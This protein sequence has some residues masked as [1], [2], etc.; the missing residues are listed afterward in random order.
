MKGRQPLWP[1]AIMRNYIRP[2]ALRAEIAKAITWHVFRHSPL[3]SRRTMFVSHYM[4]LVGATQVASGGLPL[5]GRYVPLAIALSGPAIVN[6][7][8]YH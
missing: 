5:S 4:W 7:I 8:V 1:E 2:A 6:I 3:C